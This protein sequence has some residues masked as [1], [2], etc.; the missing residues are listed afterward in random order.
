MCVL[1]C[2][3][4]GGNWAGHFGR[5]FDVGLVDGGF[6]LADRGVVAQCGPIAVVVLRV[7]AAA[8]EGAHARDANGDDGDGGFDGRPDRDVD[9]VVCLA[10]CVR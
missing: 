3:V 8:V 2:G 4:R 10:G 9:D 5:C 1:R 7:A 6:E